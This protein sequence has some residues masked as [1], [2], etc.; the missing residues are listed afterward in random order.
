[1]ISVKFQRWNPCFRGRRIQWSYCWYCPT[2]I[3]NRKWKLASFFRPEVVITTQWSCISV[4]LQRWN[5]C[6]RGRRIQWSYCRYWPTPHKHPMPPSSCYYFRSG[7]GQF[8][9]PAS[10]QCRAVSAVAALDS[11]T[12]KTWV[13]TLEFHK[14]PIRGLSYNYFRYVE[15]YFHFR[16]VISIG[17]YRGHVHWDRGPK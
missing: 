6:F 11:A 14:Y 1:M 9:F 5:P 4:K 7:K 8:P 16:L 17:Q 2:L 3:T 10:C 12:P 13:S 15:V